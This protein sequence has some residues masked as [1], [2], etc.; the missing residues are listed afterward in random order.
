[1]F[2]VFHFVI[3]NGKSFIVVQKRP[4]KNNYFANYKYYFRG[5]FFIY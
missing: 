1:M 5:Y 2:D 4:N 3:F